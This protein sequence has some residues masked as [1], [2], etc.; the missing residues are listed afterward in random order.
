MKR[1]EKIK[2]ILQKIWGLLPILFVLLCVALVAAIQAVTGDTLRS[3]PRVV[4]ICLGV[5]SFGIAL[6]WANIRLIFAD[7][8]FRVLS[9]FLKFATP[10]LSFVLLCYV[11][12]GS[13]VFVAFSYCPE[14]VVMYRGEKMVASVNSFVDVW[15]DY[16][17][18]K[19]PL[20]YGKK[21][22]EEWYGSGGY[23]PFER[24]D[25]PSVK[26]WTIYDTQGNVVEWG[27]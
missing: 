5:C 22:A 8:P 4:L 12:L 24:P 15:V 26:R 21:M 20:F 18:Y 10:V 27:P 16:Y 9:I 14:H 11:V 1:K 2:E 19:N 3:I 7:I 25:M 23:D 13:V 17:Q 6:L